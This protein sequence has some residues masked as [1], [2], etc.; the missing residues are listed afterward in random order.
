MRVWGVTPNQRIS[1]GKGLFPNISSV[2]RIS[3]TGLTQIKFA[4]QSNL[5][6]W[7]GSQISAKLLRFMARC[8]ASLI[9]PR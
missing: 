4:D 7:P 6:K 9:H 2:F 1:Y 3:P 8:S 5:N